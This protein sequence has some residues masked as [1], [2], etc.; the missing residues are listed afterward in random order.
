MPHNETPIYGGKAII[1]TND[2]GVWQF[3]CWIT[4]EG[5]YVRKS[6][7]TKVRSDAVALAEAEFVDIEY[8]RR[9]GKKL[10][11]VSISVAVENFIEYKRKQIGGKIVAGRLQT[12]KAHL[13]HF[14]RYIGESTKVQNISKRCLKKFER[15]GDEIDYVSFRL[16]E[17]ASLSTVRNEVSSIKMCFKWLY[18]EDYT[19]I[20]KLQQP[21]L[22]YSHHNVDRELVRRQTFSKDEYVDFYTKARTYVAR[23]HNKLLSDE[24]LLVRELARDYF[25]FAA[26]SGMRSGELRQLSWA[27]I[28]ARSGYVGDKKVD[29]VMVHVPA[30]TTKVR[31]ERTFMCAGSRF[32]DRWAEVSGRTSG[33]VF[34]VDGVNEISNSTI[35]RHFNK[36]LKLTNI[37]KER[38]KQLVPYSLRH[39]CVS[40]MV[41]DNGLSYESVAQALGTSVKQIER[42]Y[43]HL[44]E[45]AMF[46]T[47]V[48]R[49]RQRGKGDIVMF[50]ASAEELL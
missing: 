5:K 36:I 2:Y 25:L 3:R 47:A 20:P 50:D 40:R 6:L 18:E 12:I 1:F 29:L 37:P 11:G 13:N 19:D 10:F 15:D 48:A 24:E 31:Q 7:R 9:N 30:Q 22:A 28:T 43:L 8:R 21:E 23:S 4:D 34:S 41:L 27:N 14:L 16:D 44:N 26:N 35:V 46:K 32:L 49:Y 17:D 45:E 42:T 33:L 38:Q 39:Y